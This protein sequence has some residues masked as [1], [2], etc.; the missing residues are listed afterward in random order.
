[1]P[2]RSPLHMVVQEER[3]AEQDMAMA[4]G[5]R[6]QPL[7]EESISTSKRSRNGVVSRRGHFSHRWVATEEV[8]TVQNAACNRSPAVEVQNK[9]QK[10]QG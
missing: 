10:Y 9:V 8:A 6:E 5:V 3:L 4:L 1:M 7:S 2:P